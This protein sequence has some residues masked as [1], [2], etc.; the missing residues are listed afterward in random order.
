MSV[1]KP[2]SRLVN[3][4]LSEEEYAAMNAACE[5]SGARSLSDFARGA[6]LHAIQQAD[7]GIRVNGELTGPGVDSLVKQ[8]ESRLTAILGRLDHVS[9]AAMVNGREHEPAHNA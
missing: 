2:R 5:K 6:V 3:F 8:I 9:A 1:L 7:H 4:R